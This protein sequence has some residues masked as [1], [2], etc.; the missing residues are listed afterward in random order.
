M[1][2]AK[3]AIRVLDALAARGISP[4]AVRFRIAQGVP[5]ETIVQEAGLTLQEVDLHRPNW[6]DFVAFHIHPGM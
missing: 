5:L 3:T 2:L 4:A 6:P 1:S